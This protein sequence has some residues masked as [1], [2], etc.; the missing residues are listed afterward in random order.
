MP[1]QL[2]RKRLKRLLPK[3]PSV[4]LDVIEHGNAI[5]IRAKIAPCHLSQTL[6]NPFQAE[7]YRTLKT[8]RR[9]KSGLFIIGA[10]FSCIAAWHW[11]GTIARILDTVGLI[12]F[13]TFQ[14][15]TFSAS[16]LTELNQ[17]KD[18]TSLFLS[19]DYVSIQKIALQSS[20]RLL[21]IY[22]D[23]TNELIG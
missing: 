18:I 1:K 11:S 4:L 16:L 15:F 21:S 5:E 17:N 22:R 19:D 6:S 23:R 7:L 10:P 12:N 2:R 9:Y 8:R 3:L 14:Q 13:N 20:R